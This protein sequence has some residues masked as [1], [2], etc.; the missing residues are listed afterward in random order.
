MAFL[1]KA[2]QAVVSVIDL[3]W[4]Q[5]IFETGSKSVNQSLIRGS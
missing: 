5:Q 3:R 2:R 4:K 1:V